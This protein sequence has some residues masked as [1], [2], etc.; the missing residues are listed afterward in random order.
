M[1][2]EYRYM[3]DASS[4]KTYGCLDWGTGALTDAFK[5]GNVLP[6][7]TYGNTISA[8]SYPAS[9]A[10]LTGDITIRYSKA[11]STPWYLE[12]GIA[13]ESGYT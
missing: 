5:N 4:G 13:P 7:I 3:Q 11:D 10:E 9:W 1:S 6:I 12:G 2:I 8:D